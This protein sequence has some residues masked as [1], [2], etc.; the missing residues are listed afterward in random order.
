MLRSVRRFLLSVFVGTRK[1]ASMERHHESNLVWGP[2]GIA[3]SIVLTVV[4][5]TKHDLR[6]LLWFAW[7]CFLLGVWRLSLH[8][9][10]RAL[11]Y[12]AT[13]VVGIAAAIGLY[14]LGGWLNPEQPV[15]P[16]GPPQP[17]PTAPVVDKP[18]PPSTEP[19]EA[20]AHAP[21]GPPIKPYDLTD[22]RKKRFLAFAKPPLRD[23]NKIRIG[24]LSW[25]ERSCVA[26][27]QFLLL[28]SQAGW[29]IDQNRVFRMDE[30]IPTEGVSIVSRPEPGPPQ[31]PHLGRWHKMSLTET[32]VEA[33]FVAI[34]V[35]VSGSADASLE[36]GTTGVYF[37]SEPQELQPFK[38]SDLMAV[39]SSTLQVEIGAIE[40]Q[41]LSDVKAQ[42]EQE[43]QWD[44]DA[45]EWLRVYARD[46]VQK[47]FEEC[48]KHGTNRKACFTQARMIATIENTP[49]VKDKQR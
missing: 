38:R 31:P 42:S 3:C 43:K 25:S 7:P 19:H 33:A 37:S 16:S 29:T 2:I 47:S 17:A 12:W 21:L 14:S 10:Y 6:F 34:G 9:P 48:I 27:G 5:A 49:P 22:E 20:I 35:K 30:P 46:V 24:C 15:R 11:S 28:F 36:D 18:K 26:A 1:D 41:P 45:R 8:I 39:Q 23:A 40:D 44:R 32:S 13:A 4:A